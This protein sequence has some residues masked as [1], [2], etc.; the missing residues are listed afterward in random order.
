MRL[1]SIRFHWLHI[2]NTALKFLRRNDEDERA[3]VGPV[4]CDKAGAFQG[5]RLQFWLEIDLRDA[6]EERS[7]AEFV[8]LGVMGQWCHWLEDRREACSSM[9]RRV[10]GEVVDRWTKRTRERPTVESAA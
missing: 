1:N 2:V 5:V 6:I 8:E 9:Q 3:E 7:S 4:Q 10:G